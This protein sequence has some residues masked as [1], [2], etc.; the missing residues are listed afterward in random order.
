VVDELPVVFGRRI[1]RPSVV[2]PHKLAYAAHL[3]DTIAATRVARSA[4]ERATR[5]PGVTP[6]GE[7]RDAAAP[8]ATAANRSAQSPIAPR[9]SAM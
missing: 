8:S 2:G 1:G 7:V 6:N 9:E 4:P 5:S 3:H